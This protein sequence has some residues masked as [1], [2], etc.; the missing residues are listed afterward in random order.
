MASPQSDDESYSTVD[1]QNSV[2]ETPLS[3]PSRLKLKFMRE[4][5]AHPFADKFFPIEVAVTNQHDLIENTEPGGLKISLHKYDGAKEEVKGML[6]IDPETPL[7]MGQDGRC[8]IKAAIKDDLRCSGRR[9]FCLKVDIEGDSKIGFAVS[10]RVNVVRQSLEII[11]RPEA[12]IPEQWYKDEGGRDNCIELMIYLKDSEGRTIR[13]RQVPLRLTLL[14]ESLHRVQNQEILMLAPGSRMSIEENG[15]TL[16]RAKVGEVSKNHQKQAFRVRV[17]PDLQE[18]PSTIDVSST[19]T[20][21]IQ[22]LSKRITK[23]SKKSAV[24]SPPGMAAAA[25]HGVYRPPDHHG[26]EGHPALPPDYASSLTAARHDH[27]GTG[28]NAATLSE[29]VAGIMSWSNQVINELYNMQWVKYGCE[30]SADGSPDLSKP[31][32][33]MPNPNAM[34]NAL[35]QQYMSETMHYLQV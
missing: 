16:L 5:P 4:P 2:D 3:E 21:P 26:R 8:K 32:Y 28:A 14:Y 11:P 30:R 13:N 12:P 19:V 20:R 35:T 29:A 24:K 22:V 23:K 18:D 10:D 27:I 7:V 17:E 31:L 15:T 33:T 1:R 34:I 25:Q 9:R 6:M